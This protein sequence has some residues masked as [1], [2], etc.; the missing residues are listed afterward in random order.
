MRIK[1]FLQK[2]DLHKWFPKPSIH[3]YKDIVKDCPSFWACNWH[4]VTTGSSLVWNTNV[5]KSGYVEKAV[6]SNLVSFADEK[7]SSLLD[8]YSHK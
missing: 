7:I 8:Q 2:I 5:S 1:R 4:Y 3:V 6:Y